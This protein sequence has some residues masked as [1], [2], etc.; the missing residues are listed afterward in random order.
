MNES[1]TEFRPPWALTLWVSDRHIFAEVPVKNGGPPYIAKYP[2]TNQGLGVALNVLK[3]IHD[4]YGHLHY[5]PPA[6]KIAKRQLKVKGKVQLTP[7]QSARI[8]NILKKRGLL[9]E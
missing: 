1:C 8:S 7:E 2:L 5:D 4:Q 6:Q 9:N 3:F